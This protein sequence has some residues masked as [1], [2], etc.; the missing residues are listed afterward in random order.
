LRLVQSTVL[1]VKI[2]DLAFGEPIAEESNATAR[3][4]ESSEKKL[5]LCH[6]RLGPFAGAHT[7][8]RRTVEKKTALRM[9]SGR[10]GSYAREAHSTDLVGEPDAEAEQHAADDE[11]GDVHGGAGHGAAGEEERAAHEHD[12]LPAHRP[13]HAAGHQRRHQPGHV[14]GRREG[15]QRLA[16]VEAVLVPLGRRHPPQDVREEAPQERL[17]LRHAAFIGSTG[18]QVHGHSVSS[19]TFL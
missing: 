6:P 13:G 17:H 1:D 15:R 16:V 7:C 3:S 11:H 18:Q 5:S 12:G 19:L 8:A 9:S 2:C 14:Q 10:D 4:N